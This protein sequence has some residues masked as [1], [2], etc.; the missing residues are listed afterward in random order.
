MNM[1]KTNTEISQSVHYVRLQLC[2]LPDTIGVEL[3]PNKLQS[4]E[5]HL[6][7]SYNKLEKNIGCI[8]FFMFL[9]SLHWNLTC[10][11]L[12]R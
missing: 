5:L 7:Y 1:K 3:M 11:I 9:E 2:F 4:G 12:N 8:V 6:F 10:M